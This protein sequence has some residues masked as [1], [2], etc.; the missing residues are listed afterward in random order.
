MALAISVHFSGSLIFHGLCGQQSS[1]VSHQ[2]F[3]TV[4]GHVVYKILSSH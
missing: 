1:P 3:K 2:N 4:G